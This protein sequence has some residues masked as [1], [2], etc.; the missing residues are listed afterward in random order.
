M[1]LLAK[2]LACYPFDLIALI[3]FADV[4][5][6]DNETKPCNAQIVGS[7]QD[8]KIW[9]RSADGSIGEHSGKKRLVEEA[10]IFAKLKP[11]RG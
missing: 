7:S 10:L 1:L 9:V 3:G 11:R 5:F 8:Q 2:G 6:R 4:L